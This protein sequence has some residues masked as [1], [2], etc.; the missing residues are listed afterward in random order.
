[1]AGKSRSFN[2][3]LLVCALI[4][5]ALF[6]GCG[7]GGGGT[8]SDPL[9]TSTTIITGSIN[10]SDIRNNMAYDG[11]LLPEIR[12]SGLVGARVW[13]ES[14]YNTFGTTST[15]GKFTIVN[16]PPGRHRLVIMYKASDNTIYKKLLSNEVSVDV[17]KT[18]EVGAQDLS[19]IEDKASVRIPININT[20]TN[21]NPGNVSVS[22]WGEPGT[23]EN[24]QY[25]TPFM[26]EKEAAAIV[27]SAPGFQTTAI[28]AV[29]TNE[30]S[31]APTL[32]PTSATNRAP[33]VS[34]SASNFAV[35]KSR[36]IE[37]N[38][39]VVDP[40]N[41]WATSTLWCN[42]G[43]LRTYQ[44]NTQ[45]PFKFFWTA[46]DRELIATISF[47]AI[48]QQG[49]AASSAVSVKVGRGF[50]NQPPVISAI[51]ISPSDLEGSRQ[52]SLSAEVSDPDESVQNLNFYWAA[53]L[54]EVKP[55]N[56]VTPIWSTPPLDVA[57]TID[58]SL[59]V[60]DRFGGQA[61]A[62]RTFTVNPTKPNNPPT[63]TI[64]TPAANTQ[65][66][67]FAIATFT[68]SGFDTEDGVLTATDSFIWNFPLPTGVKYGAT[69][70]VDLRNHA[71]GN[72]IAS[73]T[74]K[75]SGSKSSTPVTRTITIIGNSV[76][77]ITQISIVPPAV[78]S[79][80]AKGTN[81]TFQTTGTDEE[82]G[83]LSADKFSWLL[84]TST[85]PITGNP[86][87]KSD[88]P[89]GTQSVKVSAQDSNGDLSVPQVA[90]VS[91]NAPPIATEVISI[92]APARLWSAGT[93]AS[94]VALLNET[95]SL[96]ATFT[97]EANDPY[98]TNT[99]S[100]KS[101][102]GAGSEVEI[103]NPASF[104][105]TTAGVHTIKVTAND[106]KAGGSAATQTTLLVN[107]RPT[108]SISSPSATIQVSQNQEIE[109][110]GTGTGFIGNV[111]ISSYKWYDL[112]HATNINSPLSEGTGLNSFITKLSVF[113]THTITL[114]GT[115]EYG[116]SS[117]T[118][119]LIFV[120]STPTVENL[121]PI[122]G[123]VQV[124]S[125]T[126]F[127]TDTE[128]RFSA[129]V[130]ENDNTDN[131]TI[132][133]Y[134]DSV[135][136]TSQV[137]TQT[138]TATPAGVTVNLTSLNFPTAID[139]GVH[140]IL[141]EVSDMWGLK[142]VASTG[143][144]IN[145]LPY[146]QSSK[147]KISTAQY[148]TAPSD[149]PVFLSTDPRKELSLSIDDFDYELNST[150]NS[151]DPAKIKWYSTGSEISFA[152]GSTAIQTFPIGYNEVTVRL[153]DTFSDNPALIDQASN[154]YK[155]AFYVW[156][157]RSMT[158]I[159]AGSVS[160]HGKDKALHFGV[161]NAPRSIQ[162]YDY[163][164]GALPVIIQKTPPES[165][166]LNASATFSLTT[167]SSI[168]KDGRVIALGKIGATDY[169][170]EFPDATAPATHTF[171]ELANATSI[172]FHPTDQTIAYFTNTS[173]QLVPFSP[174][175]W[176]LIP[177]VN[178]VTEAESKTFGQLGR[179][180]YSPIT[181]AYTSRV[182]VADTGNNRV[183]RF[184]QDT[185]ANPRTVNASS[186]VD[187]ACTNKRM[188]TLSNADSK[189]SLH[190][191]TS[192]SSK[193]LMDFGSPGTG[194]G[195]FNSPIAIYF[196][197]NDLFI[198]E[199]NRLQVIRSGETDWLK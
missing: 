91:I 40:D 87:S 174:I 181:T 196:Y 101:R 192:T 122:S 197:Q 55:G 138:M 139:A 119:R 158:N 146:A 133:W 182:C 170:V 57:T 93:P 183:V 135:A 86:V 78:D 198:L 127:D 117:I 88:F 123:G 74:T 145:R 137:A 124:A 43:T 129:T 22:V 71:L 59:T 77:I 151:Y 70:T 2:F 172:A 32:V 49:L 5:A 18:V 14:D 173:N 161:N 112:P 114:E 179:V 187:M 120:N 1:M 9:P 35:D 163:I 29:F 76:P 3:I 186:P 149:I 23:M 193:W 66:K 67:Q 52:Y 37:L 148:A 19:A 144:F 195:E 162:V 61:A 30:L 26:P 108:M 27:V 175:T 111:P 106:G 142:S 107:R 20:S 69:V 115:D 140:H 105:L 95:V 164:D 24:G 4:G 13:L 17:G 94:Y 134:L 184:L 33:N 8:S 31:V 73:L 64:L 188:L 136:P 80:Y 50:P 157:S 38:A 82:D 89:V 39:T 72:F 147:I 103:S 110:V 131:L 113:G 180:R 58:V 153:Y 99:L 65:F 130:K 160:L 60:Y 48:D 34:L 46:P 125:G 132:R 6:Y 155:V 83:N 10:S 44:T 92:S 45:S 159:P 141:C 97:N 84:G 16:V 96:L 189:V 62:T 185:L 68:A 109:L 152:T 85:T 126:R 25:Y 104:N 15:D 154:S 63:A 116:T 199:S 102:L 166:P 194:A 98:T 41:N 81:I 11:N 156:Q 7:G 190:D 128:V 165:Y 191:I 150:I 90:T 54:G 47:T 36:D 28:T 118:T 177:G 171:A 42:A 176:G 143:V 100:W 75:D 51:N 168:T 21:A 12:A 169:L 53:K 167:G 178:P 121:A 56:S 79:V